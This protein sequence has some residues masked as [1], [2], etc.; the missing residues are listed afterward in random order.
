MTIARVCAAAIALV[1]LASLA[2]VPTVVAQ[3]GAALTGVVSSQEE[4]RMEGVVVNARRQ[5]AT[6][7]VWLPAD[8]HVH[9]RFFAVLP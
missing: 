7:T 5:G 3:G 1:A 6:F 8:T 9:G 2:P 4:G